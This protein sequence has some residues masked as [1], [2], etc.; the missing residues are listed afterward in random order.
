M[1]CLIRKEGYMALVYESKWG[2]AI[3]RWMFGSI[4]VVVESR[5]DFKAGK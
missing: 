2:C 1:K 3:S 4:K 5:Q